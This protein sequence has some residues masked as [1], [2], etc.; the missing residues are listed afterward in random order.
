M[1][2]ARVARGEVSRSAAGRVECYVPGHT[3]DIMK[4]ETRSH[5][6]RSRHTS[7]GQVSTSRGLAKIDGQHK[8]HTRLVNPCG[9]FANGRTVRLNVSIDNFGSSL[10]L[11]GAAD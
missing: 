5:L 10:R 11:V 8:V 7:V 9:Q 3:L 2:R 6:H 4:E 1:H